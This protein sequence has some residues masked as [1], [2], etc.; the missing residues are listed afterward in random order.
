MREIR[1]TQWCDVHM[2]DEGARVE[3]AFTTPPMPPAPGAKPCTLD[4]C[5]ECRVRLWEPW[6]ALLADVGAEVAEPRSAR[7]VKAP[8]E[9]DDRA[10][11]TR[12]RYALTP[13]GYGYR[14][15]V[16]GCDQRR[17]S[18]HR[19]SLDGHMRYAHN[20]TL[21]TWRDEH[22]DVVPTSLTDGTPY[23][24]P[25]EPVRGA[26]KGEHDCPVPGCDYSAAG[27]KQPASGLAAHRRAHK[28]RQEVA[29]AS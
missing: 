18:P 21:R 9:P 6:R 19:S 26:D 17:P 28:R 23:V 14:C 27:L 2:R 29:A 11:I 7:A 4:L 25:D 16:P 8:A 1:V 3:S 22:G 13:D 12:R 10:L 20:V 24:D 5:D 15:P